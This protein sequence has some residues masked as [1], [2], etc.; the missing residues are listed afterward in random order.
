MENK[1]QGALASAESLSASQAKNEFGRVLERVI[2][3][4]KV[5]ITKHATPRAVLIS[6]D[7]FEALSRAGEAK[8]NTLTKEFDAILARM[9][10]SKSR[11]TMKAAFDASPRALGKAAVAATR[12]RG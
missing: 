1:Q 8:L 3:G 6:I 7:E 4:G 11:R 12:K 2:R 10:T 5:V 9:Q